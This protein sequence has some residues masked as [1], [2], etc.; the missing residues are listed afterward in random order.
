MAAV[1]KAQNEGDGDA[2]TFDAKSRQRNH[3][4]SN[5]LGWAM[6]PSGLESPCQGQLRRAHTR[7]HWARGIR[8]GAPVYQ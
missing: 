6:G 3:S 8:P 1:G 5:R 7:S 4:P 2:G